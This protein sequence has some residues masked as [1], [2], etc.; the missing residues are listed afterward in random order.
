MRTR[1]VGAAD[2]NRLEVESDA[3]LFG[4][5][6]D[7][8]GVWRRLKKRKP[9]ITVYSFVA[10]NAQAGVRRTGRCFSPLTKLDLSR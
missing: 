8:L 9:V 10:P 3:R 7:F 1:L 5:N 6:R 4:Q 2:V